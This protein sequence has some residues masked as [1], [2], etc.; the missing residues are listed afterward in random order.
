M[1]NVKGE[2]QYVTETAELVS[3]K[4]KILRVWSEK[5]LI[6]LSM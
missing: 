2:E 5:T 4:P 1:L 6:R 3:V